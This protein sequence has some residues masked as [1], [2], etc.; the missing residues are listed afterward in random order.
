MTLQEQCPHC[1]HLFMKGSLAL[2]IQ[3]EC[4]TKQIEDSNKKMEDLLNDKNLKS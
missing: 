1:G 2:H 4:K 3:N